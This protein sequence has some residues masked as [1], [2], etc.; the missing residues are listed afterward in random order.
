MVMEIPCVMLTMRKKTSASGDQ[1]G[2]ETAKG[3]VV[4]EEAV[5]EFGFER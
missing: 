1:R 2:S 4:E 3:G 5:F